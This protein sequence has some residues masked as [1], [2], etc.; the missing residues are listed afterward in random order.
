MRRYR[1][2]WLLLLLVPVIAIAGT[3]VYPT[4]VFDPTSPSS[5]RDASFTQGE[6]LNVIDEIGAVETELGASFSYRGTTNQVLNGSFETWTAGTSTAPDNW[7][8]SGTG[9]AIARASDG[10]DGSYSA[11]I[12]AG[13]A[14]S[15]LEQQPYSTI[16]STVNQHVRG[17]FFTLIARTKTSTSNACRIQLDDGVNP[18]TSSLYAFGSGNWSFLSV[19]I[20]PAVDATSTTLAARLLNDATDSSTTCRYDSVMLVEGKFIPKAYADRQLPFGASGT[21]HAKGLVPDPGATPGTTK[22]LREDATWQAPAGGGS[23]AFSPYDEATPLPTRSAFN[24]VGPLLTCSDDAGNARTNITL[25]N[26]TPV[27]TATPQPTA[28]PLAFGTP[29]VLPVFAATPGTQLSS[30]AGTSCSPAYMTALSAAGAA[31]CATPV[32]TPAPGSP[33]GSSGDIQYNSGSSTFA[34][35]AA[36]NYDATNNRLKLTGGTAATDDSLHMLDVAGTMPTTPTTPVNGFLFSITSAGSASQGNGAGKVLYNSGYTGSDFTHALASSNN[37]AGTGANLRLS[38]NGA[39]NIATA[40]SGIYADA[41]ASTSGIEI[42]GQF[43]A[44]N[45]TTAA[46]G[47]YARGIGTSAA[48]HVG[49]L[50]NATG[51]T[52]STNVKDVG[53][54]GIIGDTSLLSGVNGSFA[55][56]LQGGTLPNAS[57]NVLRADGTLPASPSG[58]AYGSY[59]NITGNG[60]ASQFHTALTVALNG[61]YSGSTGSS[62][63]YANSN[64]Q[65]TGTSLNLNSNFTAGI[66][67]ASMGVSSG[68]GSGYRVGGEF[69]GQ[70][71][72]G[73]NGGVMGKSASAVAGSNFGGIMNAANSTESS[74]PK[75]GALFAT[76]AGT[77]PGSSSYGNVSAAIFADG[78]GEDLFRGY[79]AATLKFRLDANGN[80]ISVPLKTT[81]S[82]GSKNVVCVDVS[83]GQLF[84]SSTGTDCS[85]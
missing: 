11:Q 46:I 1:Y 26:P 33:A 55:A 5:R 60:S 16:S 38:T 23:G 10:Q 35:E 75:N 77:D 74:G 85:N 28:T 25:T 76:L 44:A 37:A 4:T 9:A 17:S 84:A 51:S 13:S 72:T 2:L 61:G 29:G 8:L 53:L 67:V 22:F 42:G 48:P 24:C 57:S 49:F 12:T 14:V 78:N 56:L 41:Q 79:N 70:N 73:V 31:T 15:K 3:A 82:A 80:I 54:W 68:T 50:G 18:A 7:T 27:A 40:N 71:S 81:G 65:G 20:A 66:P 45:S 36:L 34:A 39:T 62:A 43:V 83:T 64:D 30:Y 58:S 32:P 21:N 52:E 6:M 63:I 19:T 47:A 69:E 59:I